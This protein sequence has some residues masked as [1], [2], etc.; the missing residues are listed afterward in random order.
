[1]YS[2]PGD[3][4]G[5]TIVWAK[6]KPEEYFRLD[7]EGNRILLNRDYRTWRTDDVVKFL[8]AVLLRADVGGKPKQ[9]RL[10]ELKRLNEMLITVAAD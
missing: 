4:G 8:L 2:K 6:L 10:R 7:R 9:A 1:M 5:F 3:S